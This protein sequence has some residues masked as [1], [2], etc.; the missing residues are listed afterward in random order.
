VVFEFFASVDVTAA[1]MGMATANPVESLRQLWNFE[2][3][4][5]HAAAAR[6]EPAGS[7]FVP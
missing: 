3:V 6:M 5:A 1:R 7:R 4:F 2:R